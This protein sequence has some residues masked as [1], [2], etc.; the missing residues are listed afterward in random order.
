MISALKWF[1]ML[2]YLAS[3][4]FI[5][6]SANFQYL[7]AVVGNNHLNFLRY[8]VND[9]YVGRLEHTIQIFN[10][11]SVK[12][13]GGKLVVP[14]IRNETAR[15]F[16]ILHNIPS[17]TQPTRKNDT[18]GNIYACWEDITINRNQTWSVELDYYVVSFGIS[19]LVN[20]SSITDHNVSSVL[21]RKYT[22]PEKLIESNDSNIISLAKTL[23]ANV[24]DLHERVLKIYNFAIEHLQYTVQPEE[25]GALWALQK[26]VGDCSEYSYL[27]V[28]LCRAAGIPARIQAGFA[29]H[30]FSET[31]EDGHMWAEYYLENYG[32][33]PVDATWRLLDAVDDKHFSS[34][35]SI[36]ELIPYANFIFNYT[37]GP[38][39]IDK[40]QAISVE[41]CSTNVFGDP[42]TE[43]TV[44]TVTKTKQA[45]CAIFLGKVFGTPLIFP[46]E[47]KE[48]EQAFLESE[49][50]L[51]SAI[52]SWYGNPQ[53]ARLNME[54]ALENVEKTLQNAWMLIVKTFTIFIGISVVIM[55]ITLF[56]LRRHQIKKNKKHS[57]SFIY[58]IL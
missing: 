43:N 26:G 56:F 8:E 19:Y 44:K 55:L 5:L 16:I 4:P 32:W 48:V 33:V 45:K 12:I 3:I 9:V 1:M 24:S 34:I 27:F 6:H 29:F 37:V 36:P 21:Y 17:P 47:V 25:R 52:D 51:Q 57:R 22:Q 7:S 41:P 23:T 13:R 18:S 10:N 40:K 14:I 42:I 58:M 38:K 30:T 20:S 11:A 39:Q 15:H 46:S 31:L 54:N 53:I 2:L 28:A 50:Q 35:R 49:I